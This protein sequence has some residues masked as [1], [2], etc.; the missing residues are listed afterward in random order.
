MTADEKESLVRNTLAILQREKGSEVFNYYG[1]LYNECQKYG[2]GETAFMKSVLPLAFGRFELEEK[3]PEEVIPNLNRHVTL[4]GIKCYNNLKLARTLFDHPHQAMEYLE[5]ATLLK[6]DVT[7]LSGDSNL[8]LELGRIFKSETI[9]ANRYLKVIYF[10]HPKLPFRIESTEVQTIDEFV[11][12]CFRSYT[13][14]KQAA[15]EFQHGRLQLWLNQADPATASKLNGG[16]SFYDFLVFVYKTQENL[17]YYIG[18]ELFLRPEDLL[19]KANAN[20]DFWPWVYES[21]ENNQIW[22]W[23]ENLGHEGWETEHLDASIAIDDLDYLGEEDRNLAKVQALLQIIDEKIPKPTL[24]PDV[25]KVTLTGIKSQSAFQNKIVVR[26]GEKGFVKAKVSLDTEIEGVFLETDFME[27]HHLS[28]LSE[29][30]ISITVDPKEFVRNKVYSCKLMIETLNQTLVI[31]IELKVV[32]PLKDFALENLKY[33]G[34][35]GAFFGLIRF[36]L[37]LQYPEWLSYSF[38]TFLALDIFQIEPT[39]FYAF[40]GLILLFVLGLFISGF[41]ILKKYL[42]YE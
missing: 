31:P 19:K 35:F 40:A 5:D 30:V 25:E 11:L 14:F 21:L 7:K 17:P 18:D 1:E 27:F 32:F 41:L 33:A 34:I 29:N 8:G 6:H 42:G 24:I 10:L 2:L 38:G 13:Y 22:I 15:Y 4:F 37:Y 26:L 23:L 16:Q 39:P 36:L 20:L 28:G 12:N 3:D 9:P